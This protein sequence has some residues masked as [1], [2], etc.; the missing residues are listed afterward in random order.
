MPFACEKSCKTFIASS[1]L[2]IYDL[3]EKVML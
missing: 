1:N 2:N 3:C